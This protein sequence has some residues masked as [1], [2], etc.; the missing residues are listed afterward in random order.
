MI[1]KGR[2]EKILKLNHNGKNLFLISAPT[3]VK[4]PRQKDG[5]I[6]CKAY[7]SLLS[8]FAPV[9][10][11]GEFFGDVFDV[12]ELKLT[13][14]NQKTTCEY[15]LA[16][17][18]GNRI[19]KVLVNNILSCYKKDI[20]IMGAA[21]LEESILKDFP[22]VS[23][24]KAKMIADCLYHNQNE[25][26]ESLEVLF[27]D[28]N[29]ENEAVLGI[30]ERYGDNS[31]TVLKKNPY[32][33]GLEF[34][35]PYYVVDAIA[36]QFEIASYDSRRIEGLMH[37][38]LL[39]A[40]SNGHTWVLAK[41]LAKRVSYMSERSDYKTDIP[42]IY[43]ANAAVTSKKFILD[44][45]K[46]AL[47]KYYEAEKSIALR[48]NLLKQFSCGITVTEK[49]IC[50]IEKELGFQFGKDQKKSFSLL[51][52]GGVSILTGGPGTGKTSEIKGLV[53]YFLKEKPDAVIEFCAP[54]GRA[55]KRLSESTGY[56]AKTIHKLLE[57]KPFEN[58]NSVKKTQSN[59]IHAD[60]IIVDEFSMVGVE[61]MAMFLEAVKNGTILLFVG[62]VNQL[63]SIDAGNILYDMIQSKKFPVYYL[64]ENFRQKEND[65]IISNSERILKGEKPLP[66][67]N[68]SI[69]KAKDEE[70]AY[71]G[72][73]YFMDKL[74]DKKNPFDTQLIEP[75]RKGVA[76]TYK[77]NQFVH[78]NIV[79]SEIKDVSSAP[80]LGD[81]VI[82]TMTDY[83]VGF[84]NGDIGIITSLTA[85]EMVFWNDSE[86]IVLP[87]SAMQNV[88]LAY[89]YTIHRSQGSENKNIIIYLPEE[90]SHM[91]T[92]SLFYTAVTRAKTSITVIYTGNAL[93]KCLLN[94]S[95]KQRNTRL[96]DFL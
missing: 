41:M 11:K 59:P 45:H 56:H 29:V 28:N 93:N 94:V 80:A 85:D 65:S 78:K 68:F 96:L 22:Q 81:K 70:D 44:E 14:I 34:D 19:G 61:L 43:I 51:E 23:R 52:G 16:M 40:A 9:E 18:K 30:Y 88:E 21:N 79:H 36:K 33:V 73:C 50:D 49:G 92:R 10:L 7:P 46:L 6:L 91:M 90:M 2:I 8:P 38:A 5:N 12:E 53:K 17:C 42:V 20:F 15:I 48:L 62:D 3:R 76:G 82:F 57:F 74:Y 13:Y 67:D 72:L 89:A 37:Y 75:S 86:E 63:P 84:V 32:H 64:R 35:I 26:L 47:R 27:A 1:I 55:A 24:A 39:Q 95:D 58:G 66:F 31:L 54:T 60:F 77:M 25:V 71:N 4:V 83:N 87:I 69:F